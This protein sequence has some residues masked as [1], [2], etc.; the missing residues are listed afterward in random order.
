MLTFVPL[1]LDRETEAHIETVMAARIQ[2]ATVVAIMHR[3]EA[4]ETY[5]KVAVLDEGILVDF[6]D[7]QDVKARC[8]LFS[9]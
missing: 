3:L 8:K 2:Y 6:G 4:V 1:S 5:D 9:G 7:V